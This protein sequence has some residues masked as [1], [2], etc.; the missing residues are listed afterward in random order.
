MGNPFFR[1]FVVGGGKFLSDMCPWRQAHWRCITRH[2][3]RSELKEWER[4]FCRL[5]DLDYAPEPR[6]LEDFEQ[7]V[8]GYNTGLQGT[9]RGITDEGAC[10]TRILVFS[11]HRRH[12]SSPTLRLSVLLHQLMQPSII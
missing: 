2:V 11:I 8:P 1:P 6:E 10:R 3:S 4:G 5:L 7:Q 12:R 9:A